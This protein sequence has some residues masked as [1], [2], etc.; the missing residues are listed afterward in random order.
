[1][2]I[3]VGLASEKCRETQIVKHLNEAKS[4]KPGKQEKQEDEANQ[5]KY[6]KQARQRRLCNYHLRPRG[7]PPGHHRRSVFRDKQKPFKAPK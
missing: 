1:M 4:L 7:K 5:P 3:R 2:A 6:F